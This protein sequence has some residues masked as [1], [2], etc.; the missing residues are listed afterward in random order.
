MKK[1]LQPLEIGDQ[2]IWW[3]RV[4]GGEYVF[5][6]SAKVLALTAKRVKIEADDDGDIVIRYVPPQSLQRQGK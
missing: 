2:V 3:K 5:P 4:P 1:A 6:V